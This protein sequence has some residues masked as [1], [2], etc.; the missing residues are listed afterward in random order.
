MYV[1]VCVCVC[2]LDG[3]NDGENRQSSDAAYKTWQCQDN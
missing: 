1:C 2:V 3:A